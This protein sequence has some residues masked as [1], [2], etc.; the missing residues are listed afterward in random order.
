MRKKSVYRDFLMIFLGIVGLYSGVIIGII[1]LNQRQVISQN[2]HHLNEIFLNATG[3]LL[4]YKLGIALNSASELAQSPTIEELMA[5]EDFDYSIFADVYDGITAVLTAL[6]PL[7]FE[8][9]LYRTGDDGVISSSGYFD[10]EHFL[11]FIHLDTNLFMDPASLFQRDLEKIAFIPQELVT[12]PEASTF[13]YRTAMGNHEKS[14]YAFITFGRGGTGGLVS[15][16]LPNDR[17]YLALWNQDS[18]TVFSAVYSEEYR[19]ISLN[20]AIFD[21]D[22]T[23]TFDLSPQGPLNFYRVSSQA[24]PGLYYLYALHRSDLFSLD[25]GFVRMILLSSIPLLLLGLAIVYLAAKRSYTPIKV[26][27]NSLSES[28]PFQK[29]DTHELNYILETVAKITEDHL[30]LQE[31]L[32]LSMES[33]QVKVISDQSYVYPLETERCLIDNINKGEYEKSRK[34]LNEILNRN[35]KELTLDPYT[36]VR[37]NYSL[38]NTIKRVLSNHHKSILDFFTENPALLEAFKQN[39]TQKLDLAFRS[40][41][42]SLFKELG[43]Q[44]NE[45]D[46]S[47]S[48]ILDY[49]HENFMEDLSLTMIADHFSLS[50]G[51]VSKLFKK[52]TQVKF[53]TYLSRLKVQRAKELL[54]TEN[55][56][57]NEISERVGYRN[58]NTFIRVFKELEGVSPGEY[59]K[60][61]L[62]K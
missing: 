28:M 43:Y 42:E 48:K 35:L 25:F 9:G 19:G 41:F 39:D 58:V 22:G 33:T 7:N 59:K 53:K 61:H 12:Q 37:F 26:I 56:K 55:H 13:V 30:K 6:H 45:L 8:I 15:D 46:P 57:I 24:M 32:L 36:L 34:I 49:I 16:N 20:P 11:E 3:E 2:N 62:E 18:Q 14:L 4:D 44:E 38:T 40:I 51:Y 17:G 27:V 1:A 5:M 54:E 50:E 31:D 23:F 60:M 21:G 29:D 47:A 52:A 10:Y